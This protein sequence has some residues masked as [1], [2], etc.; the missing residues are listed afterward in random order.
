MKGEYIRARVRFLATEHGGRKLPVT[1]R[2]RTYRPHLRVQPGEMLG[3][4]FD[5]G[6]DEVAPG[7][8]AEVEMALIYQHVDYSSLKSGATFEILEGPKRVVGTG[9]VLDHRVVRIEEETDAG[10]PPSS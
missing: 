4:Q 10:P 1:P 8:E 5:G 7:A 2:T 6:P 3:V 9:T